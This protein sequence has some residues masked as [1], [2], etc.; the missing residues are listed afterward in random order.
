MVNVYTS[1]IDD[2]QELRRDVLT[3]FQTLGPEKT[4]SKCTLNS[5]CP[6]VCKGMGPWLWAQDKW[7]W[8]KTKLRGYC[9]QHQLLSKV[10]KQLYE[11]A[12]L[13][14][15]LDCRS[16]YFKQQCRQVFKVKDQNE[17]FL[18]LLNVLSISPKG[19]AI[20]G[21]YICSSL[22]LSKNSIFCKTSSLNP[23]RINP[24]WLYC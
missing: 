7:A 17:R 15:I 8:E 10:R 18:W 19:N 21:F 12:V 24:I 11:I 13:Q 6:K 14:N 5:M 2:R 16:Y 22:V 1:N 9:R 4:K 3:S 23:T 20:H